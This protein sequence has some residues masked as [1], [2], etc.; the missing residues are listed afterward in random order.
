MILKKDKIELVIILAIIF[1]FIVLLF[2]YF[3]LKNRQV[4]YDANK[5]V[6]S[7]VSSIE[8]GKKPE[9]LNKINAIPH[10][11]IGFSVSQADKTIPQMRRGYIDPYDPA[12]GSTQTVTIN[13]K[14]SQPVSQVVAV[15]KTDHKTSDPYQFKLISGTDMDGQWQ[16]SWTA[17]DSYLHKYNLI[18]SAVSTNS[19]ASAEITLR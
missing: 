9:T 11:K 17:T 3:S 16:G 13:V 18:I 8:S 5:Q 14:Y 6:D 10:G 19:T 2:T 12:E 15:L 7:Y 4:K 1:A